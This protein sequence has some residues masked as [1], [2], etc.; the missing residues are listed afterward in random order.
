MLDIKK[1]EDTGLGLTYLSTKEICD[2]F[3]SR[4]VSNN[5]GLL[6]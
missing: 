3:W 1:Q 5:R 4:L 6:K 2:D